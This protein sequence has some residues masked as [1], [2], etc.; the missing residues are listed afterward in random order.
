MTSRSEE[1]EKNKTSRFIILADEFSRREVVS[2]AK[3]TAFANGLDLKMELEWHFFDSI[4]RVTVTG[5][6]SDVDKFSQW[7][8]STAAA[9]HL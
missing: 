7:L 4:Y 1:T 5:P 2:L 9:Y 3:N 6:S 8:I